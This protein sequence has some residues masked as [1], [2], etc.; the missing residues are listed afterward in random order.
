MFFDLEVS[1]DAWLNA[2]NDV[3]IIILKQMIFFMV[4]V[5]ERDKI[6]MNRPQLLE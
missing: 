1:V 2:V 3:V 6:L 4:Y 5:F